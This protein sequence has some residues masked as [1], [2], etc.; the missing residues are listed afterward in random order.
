MTS[1]SA[2]PKGSRT[3]SA[4][5]EGPSTEITLLVVPKSTPMTVM[6]EKA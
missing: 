1:S 4:E 5:P 3:V 6:G 2:A